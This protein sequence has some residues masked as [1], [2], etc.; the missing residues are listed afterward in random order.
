MRRH[1]LTERGDPVV[2]LPWA[3]LA[4]VAGWLA[5]EK[6]AVDEARAAIEGCLALGLQSPF[7]ELGRHLA[8][9]LGRLPASVQD[10]LATVRLGP[11]PR[12]RLGVRPVFELRRR[13]SPR[14]IEVM[15]LAARGLSNRQIGEALGIATSTA[16]LH[17]RHAYT[18]LGA[19][20]RRTALRR[21]RAL[22]LLD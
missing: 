7:I 2:R 8:P 6:A 15:R 21:A 9:R 18:K 11:A 20:G 16:G 14:E 10:A 13:L 4:A 3:L 1:A 17:L 19:P 12:A 22:G 5:G